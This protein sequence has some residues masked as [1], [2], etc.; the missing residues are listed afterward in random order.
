MGFYIKAAAWLLSHDSNA[1]WLFWNSWHNL[2][3]F[4][5]LSEEGRILGLEPFVLKTKFKIYEVWCVFILL[6]IVH[7]IW[8]S[9]PILNFWK[10]YFCFLRSLSRLSHNIFQVVL[11]GQREIKGNNTLQCN[12]GL[13]NI[14]R[15]KATT[16]YT[17]TQHPIWDPGLKVTHGWTE[18]A[19]G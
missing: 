12:H 8:H 15:D 19:W 14:N 2:W 4:F 6:S 1:T 18:V 9:N 11:N 5:P 10:V 7:N 16:N 3:F 13:F 17:V